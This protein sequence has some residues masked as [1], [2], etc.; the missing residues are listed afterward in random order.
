VLVHMLDQ[1]I[2]ID[3]WMIGDRGAWQGDHIACTL[4]NHNT[5]ALFH[6]RI[7]VVVQAHVPSPCSYSF[8]GGSQTKPNGGCG[9]WSGNPSVQKDWCVPGRPWA[10][11]WRPNQLDEMMKHS[12]TASG[13]NE[14]IV[15]ASDW[16]KALPDAVAAI[17]YGSEANSEMARGVHASFLARFERTAQQ[18]PLLYMDT[19]LDQ[20]FRDVS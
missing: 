13:Y 11:S 17:V 3:T 1:T 10:C 7:G 16:N 15:L 9:S 8:D 19:N 14:V 6:H 2:N 20:P 4:V 18:T 12:S 5:R